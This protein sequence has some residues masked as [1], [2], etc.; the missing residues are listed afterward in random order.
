MNKITSILFCLPLMIPALAPA[1]ET[2]ST[3]RLTVELRDGSRV[4]GESVSKKMEFHSPLLGDLKLDVKN[5][6]SVDC[7]SA[8]SAKLVTSDGDTLTVSFAETVLPVKTSFGKVEL[9]VNG[10]RTISVS[11][12]GSGSEAM[13]G[14]VA[15]YP[16]NGNAEDASGN[17]NN[18]VINNATPTTDRFG[19]DNSAFAFA[20]TPDSKITIHSTNLLLQPPFSCSLWVKPIGGDHGPRVFSCGY[21]YG[22]FEIGIKAGSQICFG[23]V[24]TDGDFPCLSKTSCSRGEWH[25]VV[26][27]RSADAMSLYLDGRLDNVVVASGSVLYKPGFG[28]LWWPTFGGSTAIGYP[29]D[30]FAG[31]VSDVRFYNRALTAEEI[32]QAYAADGKK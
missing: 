14:L 26:A 20:G 27:V 13:R 28:S 31:S 6:R 29:Y 12:L 30:S 4:V 24:T 23:S 22:G 17:G 32:R 18:G 2:N 3:P 9:A 7:I 5:I 25:Y 16:L 15:W 10:I 1:A 11:S 19:N 8:N 21:D